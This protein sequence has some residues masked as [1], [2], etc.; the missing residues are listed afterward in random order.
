MELT[1]FNRFLANYFADVVH[2]IQNYT[3]TIAL[4]QESLWNLILNS[5]V[6]GEDAKNINNFLR[7]IE[8]SNN[9]IND[10]AYL[11]NAIRIFYEGKVVVHNEPFEYMEVVNEVIEK[12]NYKFSPNKV[13]IKLKFECGGKK[14][15]NMDKESLKYVL[16]ML[17]KIMKNEVCGAPLAVEIECGEFF[18]IKVYKDGTECNYK[19]NKPVNDISLFPDKLDENEF[20][21][22]I[23]FFVI[24]TIADYYKGKFLLSE[25]NGLN[26]IKVVF[27]SV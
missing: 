27:E 13:N 11:I 19:E 24:Y 12:I 18:S 2:D 17:V 5:G 4:G 7:I 21:K 1:D 23:H 15:I 3:I 9:K 20:M 26:G 10:T 14:E 16:T 22:R 6:K 8:N 25:N